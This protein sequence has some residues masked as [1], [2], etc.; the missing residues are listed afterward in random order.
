MHI[1]YA[2]PFTNTGFFII[3]DA[4]SK[5][6]EMIRTSA[7]VIQCLRNTFTRFGLPQTNVSDNASNFMSMEILRLYGVTYVTT[8]P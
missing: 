2:G 1:D 4:C 5:W 7:M 3:V 8:T 6:V